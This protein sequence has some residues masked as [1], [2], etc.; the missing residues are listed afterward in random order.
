M[1]KRQCVIDIDSEMT[2]TSN[3][4]RKISEFFKILPG[5]TTATE[6]EFATTHQ[7][8]N[9]ASEEMLLSSGSNSQGSR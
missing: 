6:S 9:R 5:N 8:T 7:A 1:N 2:P 3:K 4:S